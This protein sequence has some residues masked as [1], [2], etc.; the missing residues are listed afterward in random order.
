MYKNVTGIIVIEKKKWDG[1]WVVELLS[2]RKTKLQWPDVLLSIG[3]TT[4]TY[5][6]PIFFTY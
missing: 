2:D 1:R 3:F 4:P 6:M 5:P